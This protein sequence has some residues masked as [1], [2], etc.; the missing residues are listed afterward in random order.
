MNLI[1]NKITNELI[2]DLQNIYD[3]NK[4]LFDKNK[5]NKINYINIYHINWDTNKNKYKNLIEKLNLESD[6]LKYYI[7]NYN[8]LYFGFIK[9]YINCEN[10][11]FHIDYNG[12]T[13][14]FFIPFIDINYLNATEYLYFYNIQNNYKYYNNLLDITNKFNKKEDL[15]DYLLN[16][17]NLKYK[18]D[19]DIQCIEANMFSLLELPNYVL[20]R[21][22][23]NL[24]NKDRVMF[25]ITFLL[26]EIDF[27]IRSEKFIKDAELDDKKET[28]L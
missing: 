1:K 20:H 15:I 24:S 25:Q 22:I 8:I 3:E 5:I 18:V 6:I 11:S 10:Q 9:S 19:Y 28:I 21:G 14:T 2:T 17:L 7:T 12:K 27:Y 26:E 13:I 16:Q 4:Y 23:K